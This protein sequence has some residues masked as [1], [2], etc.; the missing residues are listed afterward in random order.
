MNSEKLNIKDIITIVLLALINV[1][2]F[3]ASSLLYVSPITILLMPIIYS[4][5]EG[6]VFFTIGVKVPKK[7]ALF[8]YC[9]VR[10]GLG[11]Y[12]PYIVCYLI[13]GVV[14]ELILMKG[15]YAKKSFLTVCYMLVQ[16][17]AS[18]GGTFYPYVMAYNSFFGNKEDFVKQN[19]GENILAAADI[20]HSWVA[21]ALVAGILVASFIGAMIAQ[22]IM[23][24]HLLA[25]VSDETGVV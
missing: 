4:V 1:L 16:L 10:G 9:A 5:L 13:A 22:K 12:L 3:M 2:L 24:K 15:N 23:K 18:V 8:I 6:I 11:G 7:G 21:V 14:A 19:N 25:D 20:L 17:I